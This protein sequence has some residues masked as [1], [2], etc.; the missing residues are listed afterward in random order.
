[1][2]ECRRTFVKGVT[3]GKMWC[4]GLRPLL[5]GSCVSAYTNGGENQNDKKM[6]SGPR[7]TAL[8]KWT[9]KENIRS[10]KEICFSWM[11]LT[12][13]VTEDWEALTSF[14]P[15]TLNGLFWP[16]DERPRKVFF[17]ESEGWVAG[18]GGGQSCQ[19]R[20]GLRYIYIYG[21]LIPYWKVKGALCSEKHV[22]WIFEDI[23]K[24][25][26]YLTA[27]W[28]SPFWIAIG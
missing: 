9:N 11:P 14:Q 17:L 16:S 25:L 20:A 13:Q 23:W 24:V 27:I 3:V 15:D 10:R 26:T 12:V 18:G 7:G 4:A 1:M 6:Y 2:Y 19:E 21:Y 8:C 28:N 22:W 5:W